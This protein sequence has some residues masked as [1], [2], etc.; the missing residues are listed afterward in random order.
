MIGTL[1][2]GAAVGA[3]YVVGGKLGAAAA[4]AFGA[5]AEVTTGAMWGGRVIAF[6]VVVALIGG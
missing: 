5:S 1:K 2:L 4:S 3:A 6:V